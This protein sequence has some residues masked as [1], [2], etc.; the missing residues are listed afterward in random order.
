MP[1][2]RRRGRLEVS[3][4]EGMLEKLN[5][6]LCSSC[7]F[8]EYLQFCGVQKMGYRAEKQNFSSRSAALR[9]NKPKPGLWEQ[10]RASLR[11][12]ELSF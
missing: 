6:T 5:P 8:R 12:K 11:R 3:L 2:G 9:P 1:M 7:D 4:A 10:L